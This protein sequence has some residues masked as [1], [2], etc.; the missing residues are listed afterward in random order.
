M[1]DKVEPGRSNEKAIETK[2]TIYCLFYCIIN[3]NRYIYS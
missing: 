2:L 3:H 1:H